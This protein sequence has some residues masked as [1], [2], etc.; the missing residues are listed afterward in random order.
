MSAQATVSDISITIRCPNPFAELF[1]VRS[2][3]SLVARGVGQ[4][5]ATV[6]P[7]VFKVKTRVGRTETEALRLF[8]RD[9]TLDVADP[10]PASS[11]PLDK[12]SKTHEYH[13]G[14]ATRATLLPT[15]SYGAGA[16]IFLMARRWTSHGAVAPPGSWKVPA[17][18]TLLDAQRNVVV[19]FGAAATL[20]PDPSHEPSATCTVAVAPG[21]YILRTRLRSGVFAEQTVYASRGWQIRLFVLEDPAI[22]G[23]A[24]GE[25]AM[26]LSAL[27]G[28]AISMS[29]IGIPFNPYDTLAKSLELVR[30][31]LTDGRAVFSPAVRTLMDE[32][33]HG[34]FQDPIAGLYGAHLMLMGRAYDAR[35]HD[36]VGVQLN[37]SLHEWVHDQSL[38]DQVVGNLRNLLGAEHPDVQALSLRS[39]GPN[40]PPKTPLRV[41]P[42]LRA[43]WLLFAEAS[44]DDPE[45][46]P[47]AVWKPIA[48]MIP[49]GP[50]L[51]WQPGAAAIHAAVPQAIRASANEDD[52]RAIA[53][54]LGVPRSVLDAVLDA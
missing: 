28:M 17:A 39:D 43:S 38:Y 1:L 46:V 49:A 37:A 4:L 36:E 14:A 15:A 12:T 13:M 8:E 34:K 33:L 48:A 32:L 27:S 31:A 52:R 50:F 9:E 30:A 11:I 41:A 2:D 19:D 47:L 42:M 26:D 23:N 25:P 51:V 35:A 53:A 3:Y 5:R 20:D 10:E 29:P 6:Q 54:S 44:N 7:G 45:L 22:E 40:D 16:E 21:P 18:M 24:P